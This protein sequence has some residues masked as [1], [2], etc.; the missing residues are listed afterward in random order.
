MLTVMKKPSNER[1]L[2]LTF[3]IAVRCVVVLIVGVFC[4]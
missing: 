4:P 3:P 2:E 1:S